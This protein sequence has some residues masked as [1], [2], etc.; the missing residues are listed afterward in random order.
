[1]KQDLETEAIQ[2]TLSPSPF[3]VSEKG[4]CFDEGKVIF[5][6]FYSIQEQI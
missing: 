4:V 2:I 5:G 3:V 6:I 1:V